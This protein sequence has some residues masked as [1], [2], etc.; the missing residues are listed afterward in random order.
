MAHENVRAPQSLPV[1]GRDY[2]VAEPHGD[3]MQDRRERVSWYNLPPEERFRLANE[4]WHRWNRL[5]G[6]SV[7]LAVQ[8]LHN[9][10]GRAE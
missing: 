8:S 6:N 3:V 10:F 7:K 2:E 5:R 9:R 1:V 4:A